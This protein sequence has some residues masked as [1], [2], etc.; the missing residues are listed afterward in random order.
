MFD[1]SKSNSILQNVCLGVFISSESLGFF[2][3]S[4]GNI[5]QKADYIGQMASSSVLLLSWEGLD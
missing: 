5:S 2:F 1:V 4:K 3:W